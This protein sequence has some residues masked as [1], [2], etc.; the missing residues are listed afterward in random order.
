MRRRTFASAALLG[1]VGTGGCLSRGDD[2]GVTTDVR[3]PEQVTAVEFDITDKGAGDRG[4]PIVEFRPDQSQVVVTGTMSAGNPCHEARPTDLSYDDPSETL[5][6]A[7][8]VEQVRSGDCPDSLGTN[9]Y[10]LRLSLEPLP[11]VVTARQTDS[12]D[13]TTETT[14]QRPT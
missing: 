9:T 3:V 6:V 7:V 12:D 10:E 2:G 14:E 13:D 5:S 4:P 11:D 1:L 8:G